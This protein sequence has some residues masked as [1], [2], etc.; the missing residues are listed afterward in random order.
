MGHGT[1]RGRR[2]VLIGAAAVALGGCGGSRA[3]ETRSALS[4]EPTSPNIEFAKQ[5]IAGTRYVAQNGCGA[6]GD[7]A[8]RDHDGCGTARTSACATIAAALHGLPPGYEVAIEAGP[9]P[10]A[11]PPYIDL[12]GSSTAPYRLRGVAVA[13]VRPRIVPP[14]AELLTFGDNAHYWTIEGLHLD[15][16]GRGIAGVYLVG[17]AHVVVR[18]V[19]IEGCTSAAVG[20]R[21]A[22]HV[23][24]ERNVMRNNRA[25]TRAGRSLGRTDSNGVAM[26]ANADDTLE[27]ADANAVTVENGAAYVRIA[28]NEAHGNS[29]DGVQCAGREQGDPD[30]RHVTIVGNRFHGNLENGIDVKSCQDVLVRGNDLWNYGHSEEWHRNHGMC[31]G[32]ALV[33][34]YEAARVRI[35]K[36]RIR[37]SGVGIIVGRWDGPG[38]TDVSIRENVIYNLDQRLTTTWPS[39]FQLFN[40]GDGITVNRGQNVEVAHNTL[41]DIPHAG[42]L[43]R[44]R[45]NAVE[46]GRNIRVWNNV[47]S[48]VHGLAYFDPSSPGSGTRRAGEHGGTVVIRRGSIEGLWIE[49]NLYFHPAGARFR[50]DDTSGVDLANWRTLTGVDASAVSAAASSEGDP[51]F[52]AAAAGDFVL[53]AG[54]AA[55]GNALADASNTDRRCGDPPAPDR[56]AHESDCAPQS[57]GTGGTGGVAGT[58]TVPTTDQP[59]VWTSAVNAT[60]SGS[61]LAKT[62]GEPW[63]E[64][65]G[66]VSQQRVTSGDTRVTFRV[67]DTEAFRFLG[68]SV[69]PRWAG[70]AGMDFSFRM[71]AGYAD[72][73]E[74]NVWRFTN[75]IVAGDVLAIAFQGG[76][77]QYF[78]NGALIY[79]SASPPSYPTAVQASFIDMGGALENVTISAP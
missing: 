25:T 55:L 2:A 60:A 59:V 39:G 34:H 6:S 40:C 63:A 75:R 70:A 68:F 27:R 73:Y 29:G 50:V 44:P 32:A 72:V 1:R 67:Y 61:T 57:T 36:N 46:D 52:R 33:V 66:A 5:S 10:Y 23:A 79:T 11:A 56:G 8:C 71:Q 3:H 47:V 35:E 28:D 30:S 45:G 19:L 22:Q 58:P 16:E 54:S 15:C 26:R 7:Q 12:A 48:S 69:V 21:G 37:E 49:H 53:T 18:D 4:A 64:D 51:K 74:R 17:S 78:K 9:A 14:G 13:G 65:A 77:V 62:G 20:V 38:V 41:H 43:V 31:G 42:I 76:R 24:I